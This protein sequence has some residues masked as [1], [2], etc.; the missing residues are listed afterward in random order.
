[1][2]ENSD[3]LTTRQPSTPPEPNTQE[4]QNGQKTTPQDTIRANT[5]DTNQFP[6]RQHRTTEHITQ[7]PT[8]DRPQ[9]TTQTSA[10]NQA[11]NDWISREALQAI[12]KADNKRNR[13]KRNLIQ[14]CEVIDSQIAKLRTEND[15]LTQSLAK[16][17]LLTAR[18]EHTFTILQKLHKAL[19]GSAPIKE[20]QKIA[21]GLALIPNDTSAG[22]EILQN[23]AKITETL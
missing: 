20:V 22:L 5:A 3:A 9:S 7:A 4:P 10:S 17:I 16:D 2:S 1:M 23:H 21:S 11:P 19:P 12:K 18:K 14:L 13:T 8:Q 6:L 15:K